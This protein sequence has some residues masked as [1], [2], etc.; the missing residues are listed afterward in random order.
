MN[1]GIGSGVDFDIAPD[2]NLD[3]DFSLSAAAPTMSPSRG[4]GLV[5]EKKD[6]AGIN[7]KH[8]VDFAASP[9]VLPFHTDDWLDF[10]S[11]VSPPPP[12][13]QQLRKG[14]AGDIDV[15]IDMHMHME[16]EASNRAM[17]AA[18]DFDGA[19]LA[20]TAAAPTTA[21]TATSGVATPATSAAA[22][23]QPASSQQMNQQEDLDAH[24]QTDLPLRSLPPVPAP[25]PAVETPWD[26][27][28]PTFVSVLG[29]GVTHFHMADGSPATAAS[30]SAS[31]F[32]TLDYTVNAEQ[33]MQQQPSQTHTLLSAPSTP[34]LIVHP[35]STKS[36]VETQIP[37]KLTLSPV[38]PGVKK[39]RLPR[40]S[41]S[42]FKFL[43]KPGTPR[44]PDV[45]E[46]S[47]NVV[48]TS[49][50]QD[51]A[52]LQRAL[53]RARGQP[54]TS[55]RPD[56]DADADADADTDTDPGTGT[57]TGNGTAD[58]P[59]LSGGDVK[60]CAN[61]IKRERKRANRKKQRKPEEEEIF[62]RDEEKRI[63]VFNTYKLINPLN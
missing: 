49:T 48:C 1:T 51:P 32:P 47:A 56:A 4:D 20:T 45:L 2:L 53:A 17:D 61:C 18:F 34:L 3:L 50:M 30:A 29:D 9:S 28:S 63:I 38:P 35:T 46:L 10:G 37:I 11:F 12:A 58:D 8:D 36:R 15:D 33:S 41:V 16:L 5:V 44:S 21:T 24:Q 60:I 39:L 57:G 43:A 42:K 26:P 25:P 40:H 59:P 62:Q 19:A 22:V 52:K 55:P 13:P 6:G 27:R 23:E 14:R 54:H 31:P 7:D